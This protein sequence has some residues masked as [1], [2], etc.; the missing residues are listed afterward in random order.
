MS[1]LLNHN[2]KLNDKFWTAKT[3]IK[4]I[5]S[6][7][8]KIVKYAYA[9]HIERLMY[10]G[11]FMLLCQ[12]HPK[13]VYRIFMEWSIDS[14]D[15]LSK[16]IYYY[17][18]YS[19]YIKIN[20]YSNYIMEFEENIKQWYTHFYNKTELTNIDKS[21]LSHL[22]ITLNAILNELEIKEE[23]KSIDELKKL[24]NVDK[25]KIEKAFYN[26]FNKMKTIKSQSTLKVSA[27]ICRKMLNELGMDK[28]KLIL[29]SNKKEKK[30]QENN[31]LPID[32]K[33]I[34]NNTELYKFILD[35]F[36]FVKNQTRCRTLQ[37]QKVLLRYW[38][39]LLQAFGDLKTL[40]PNDL[41]F[42]IKNV[43]KIAQKVVINDYYI[44][45]LH[46]LFYKLNDEWNIK[47]KD[48]KS[49]FTI[50]HKNTNE[51]DGDKDKLS[52]LQQEN[53]VKACGNTLEKLVILLLF[54]TGMR[55]GGLTNIKKKDI[56]DSDKN[57]AKD[58]GSTLEKGNKIRK[59]PIFNIVKHHIKKWIEENHM[60]NS[61]YLFPNRN[62]H[63]KPKTTMFFQTL[64]KKIA[65]E[66]G[67]SGKE[68]H[69]HSA[70]HSVA[71][72]LLEAG[73]S[74]DDIGRFLGHANPATTAKFYTKLSAQENIERMNTECLGG[75]NFK[76]TRVPQLPNFKT[77]KVKPHKNSISL[78]DKI[79]KLEI[80]GVS[81]EE[82]L[83]Q[84]KLDKLRQ[85]RLEK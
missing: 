41:D 39:N 55:V 72:N 44:I 17:H 48:L 51:E 9:H 50:K 66:A 82:E 30:K 7:I 60:I 19:Y 16:N 49:Y 2:N 13:E 79:K 25:I 11:N 58:F 67:Y 54:T 21:N 73:N 71:H 10:L 4:L 75:C 28:N 32:L 53:M 76:D 80:D 84:R 85:K 56:F 46:H 65:K 52:P 22:Y 57:E 68:I 43:T 14:Y 45:Y 23:S 64:F 26:A 3:N 70:R 69:I 40:N 78:K 8:Q 63:S 37:T 1:N 18:K 81:I 34:K 36:N 33:D 6:I 31:E 35:R 24:I 59:F 62:D 20:F 29:P 83:L 5:D 61:E 47:L 74:L 15:W 77:K 42:S 27:S 12:I 38:V